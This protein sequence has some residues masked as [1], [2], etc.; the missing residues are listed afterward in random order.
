MRF[1]MKVTM[2]NDPFNAY[3]KDG[4]VGKKLESILGETKPEAVYFTEIHGKRVGILVVN[5]DQASQMAKFAEPWFIKF[6]AEVEFHPAM[7][8]ED[9]KKSNLDEIGKKMK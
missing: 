6:N 1:L 8:V 3:I 9:L 2:P 5:M 7:L 4:S